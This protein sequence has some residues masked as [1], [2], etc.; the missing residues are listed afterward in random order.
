MPFEFARIPGGGTL[1]ERCRVENTPPRDARSR[2]LGTSSGGSASP[3]TTKTHPTFSRERDHFCCFRWLLV[4]VFSFHS[5]QRPVIDG[6]K[7]PL[8]LQLSFPTPTLSRLFGDFPEYPFV[9][10]FLLFVFQKGKGNGGEHKEQLN[11]RL[12]SL[13]DPFVCWQQPAA[14]AERFDSCIRTQFASERDTDMLTA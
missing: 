2:W 13:P 9:Q 1:R 8:L 10:I 4:P 7:I 12:P 6:G 3:T 11:C 14:S 5:E